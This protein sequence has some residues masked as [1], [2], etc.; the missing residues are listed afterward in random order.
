MAI[1]LSPKANY[2]TQQSVWG[3]QY[4][5]N[6]T[7]RTIAKYQKLGYY[8]NGFVRQEHKAKAVSKRKLAIEKIFKGF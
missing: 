3:T 2:V 5:K 6:L 4:G 8:S 1:S 7:D